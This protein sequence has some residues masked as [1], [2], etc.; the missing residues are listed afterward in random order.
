[1]MMLGGSPH[2]VAAP[3][4]L[5]QKTSDRIIGTG[6]KHRICASSSVTVARNSTTVMLSMNMARNEDMAMKHSSSGTTW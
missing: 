3:P 4:R 1:M 5:A 2:M 6:S